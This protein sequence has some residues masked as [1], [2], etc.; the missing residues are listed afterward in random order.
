LLGPIADGK[1]ARR[2][3]PLNVRIYDRFFNGYVSSAIV[4][5]DDA[6]AAPRC[7]LNRRRAVSFSTDMMYGGRDA[8]A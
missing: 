7:Y 3:A 5:Q 1:V 6:R 4:E 2:G 8:A